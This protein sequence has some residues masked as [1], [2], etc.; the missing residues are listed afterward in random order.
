[1]KS[2][3]RLLCFEFEG[4]AKSRNARDTQTACNFIVLAIA[5][6][7]TSAKQHE[8]SSFSLP[9]ER[10]EVLGKW[11][12]YSGI[13][14]LKNWVKF[15]TQNFSKIFELGKNFMKNTEANFFLPQIYFF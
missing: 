5:R 15:L 6:A 14:Y 7:K 3:K 11:Y 1:L 8:T 4:Y 9:C 10:L 12:G 2:G 13:L